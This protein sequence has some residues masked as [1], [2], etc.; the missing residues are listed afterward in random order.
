MS[1]YKC[2]KCS[3]KCKLFN[4]MTRHLTKNTSCSKSLEGYNYTEE[5]LIKLSLLQFR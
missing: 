4:D 3:Y 5:E 1:T 2:L